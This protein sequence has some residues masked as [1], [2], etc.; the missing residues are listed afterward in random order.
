MLGMPV[1]V[2]DLGAGIAARLGR[3]RVKTVDEQGLNWRFIVLGAIYGFVAL[4]VLYFLFRPNGVWGFGLFMDAHT[5]FDV[6]RDWMGGKGFQALYPPSVLVLLVPFTFAPVIVWEAVPLAIL[7]YM[8]WW[9]RPGYWG[10]VGIGLCLC[11]PTTFGA[12]LW[13][14]PSIWIVAFVALATRWPAFGPLVLI[15][16]TL[17]PF[18]LV[19]VLHRRWWVTAGLLAASTLVTL[20]MWFDWITVLRSVG[21][22]TDSWAYSLPVVPLMMIPLIAKWQS[23]AP[24]APSR[25][26]PGAKDLVGRFVGWLPGRG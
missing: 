6:T 20:P 21:A 16:P 9:W 2:A 12:Y 25:E 22:S 17:A 4:Q 10:L 5:L 3:A 14:N 8:V 7:V 13:A 11:V 19:G 26:H 23:V 15:K 24:H 18:A 1:A